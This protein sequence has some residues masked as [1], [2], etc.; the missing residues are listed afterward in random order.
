MQRGTKTKRL[1]GKKLN[2]HKN[3]KEA[4]QEGA[5]LP[6]SSVR[7]PYNLYQNTKYRS[8]CIAT[9]LHAQQHGACNNSRL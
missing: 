9:Q 7:L 5:E 2:G 1:N 8:L 6:L 4:M 3:V